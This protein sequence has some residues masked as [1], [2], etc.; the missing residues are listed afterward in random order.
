MIPESL[1]DGTVTLYRL[2]R[3]PDDWVEEKVLVPLERGRHHLVA[4]RRRLLL[5]HHAPR[6]GRSRNEDL[7]FRGRFADGRMAT[8]S[9][10][11]G[12][13]RRT[14]RTRCRSRLPPSGAALPPFS[15]PGP[16]LWPWTAA[17]LRGNRRPLGRIGTQEQHVVCRWPSRFA[18]PGDRGPH[19]QFL[20]RSRGDRRMIS[21]GPRVSFARRP[22]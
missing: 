12:L 13:E 3:F 15:G 7:P 21:P 2:R 5:L 11:A 6:A 1:S 4:R 22:R 10:Q 20:R 17:D 9:G 16:G 18:L 19:I 8:P 14:S